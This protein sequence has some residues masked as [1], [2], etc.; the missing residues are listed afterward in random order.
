MKKIKF[1]MKA[2]E[3]NNNS[4]LKGGDVECSA[5][6]SQGT[7]FNLFNPIVCQFLRGKKEVQ[8]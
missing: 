7:F 1:S 3:R 4:S 2:R 5:K 8:Q 6:A